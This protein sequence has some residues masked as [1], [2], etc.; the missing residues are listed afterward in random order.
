MIPSAGGCRHSVALKG[1]YDVQTIARGIGRTRARGAGGRLRCRANED[2]A[3]RGDP[4]SR[5]FGAAGISCSARRQ[6][7]QRQALVREDRMLSVP[8]RTGTGGHQGPRLGPRP[9]PFQ[10]FLRYTRTPIGE[11]PPYKAKVMSDRDVADVY[12]FLQALPPPPPLSTLPLL[13]Q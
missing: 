2:R 7:R 12:A 3:V 6:R 10:A 1:R 4:P 5:S 9:I 11:M 13:Q 8:Q